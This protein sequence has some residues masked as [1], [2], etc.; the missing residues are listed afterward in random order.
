MRYN[1]PNLWANRLFRA[2]NRYRTIDTCYLVG[3]SGT[4]KIG[5]LYTGVRFTADGK[6]FEVQVKEVR[7]P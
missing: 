4:A 2:L 3:K 1:D 5:E 7:N 6:V